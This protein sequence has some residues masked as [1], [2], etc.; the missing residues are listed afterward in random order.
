MA[1][2]AVDAPASFVGKPVRLA[3]QLEEA[4]PIVSLADE[5]REMY[6]KGLCCD[7]G[8]VGANQ[9]FKAHKAV[10]AARS[11][12]WKNIFSS[13]DKV[14]ELV[15]E[16]ISNA[17]A[18]RFML[19]FVYELGDNCKEEIPATIQIIKDVLTLARRYELPG[20]TA[21]ATGWL[22]RDV[23]THDAVERLIMCREFGLENLWSKILQQIASNKAALAEVASSPKIM[24]HPELMQSLLQ[25][26]ACSSAT[27][28]E[29]EKV[30][31]EEECIQPK[32]KAK[33]G[34]G[35]GGR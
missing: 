14:E 19:E 22:A 27:A 16:D 31:D 25:Q 20:L 4:G 29:E 33:K 34:A 12:A 15:L 6:Q 21:R 5:L 17:E 23:T 2:A 18:V 8:L 3:V 28:E 32:K 24:L 35:K 11:N 10:L 9:C 13:G 26:T 1:V 30:P 7:I